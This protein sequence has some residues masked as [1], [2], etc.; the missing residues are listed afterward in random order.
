MLLLLKF[1]SFYTLIKIVDDSFKVYI[2][3][4]AFK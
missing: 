4:E 3:F 1:I 2:Q